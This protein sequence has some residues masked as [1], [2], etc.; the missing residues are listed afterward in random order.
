MSLLCLSLF[1]VIGDKGKK[2]V[3]GP[4]SSSED[5]P[6]KQENNSIIYNLGSL[7]N[8]FLPISRDKGKKKVKQEIE[9]V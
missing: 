2:R 1:T 6:G 8:S 5:E 9:K 7:V 3:L 4:S